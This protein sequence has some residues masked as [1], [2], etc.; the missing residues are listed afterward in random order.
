MDSQCIISCEILKVSKDL[1]YF[2]EYLASPSVLYSA[3]S[4]GDLSLRPQRTPRYYLQSGTCG[5]EFHGGGQST[6]V[7]STGS[8]LK[9]SEIFLGSAF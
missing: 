6:G 4:H 8:H 3:S 1:S 2:A 5:G 9:V 7:K